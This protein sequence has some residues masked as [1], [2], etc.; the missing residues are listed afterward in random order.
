MA[1]IPAGYLKAVVSLGIL[2][3]SFQHIGTGFLYSHPLLKSGDR[4][5]HHTF[6]VTN[7]HVVE[8]HVSHVRFDRVTDG[9]LDVQPI[10][11]V[12]SL[13]WTLHSDGA[14]V[15][16]IPVLSP[17]PIMDGR[18]MVKPEVFLGDVGSP[19][20]QEWQHITEGNGVYVIGFPLGLIGRARN[21]PIIRQGV[22]SRIQ[23]WLSG[24]ETTFL[25]DSPAF[26]GNSGGPVVLKPE[27]VAVKGTKPITHSLL[28]GMVSSNISSRE[29][30]ISAQTNRPRIVFEENTGLA[31]VVPIDVIKEAIDSSIKNAGMEGFRWVTNKRA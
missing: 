24:D 6:L 8:K 26:P 21:Y 25:I 11:S 18:D 9:S 14:D 13:D 12:T 3:E 22:I 17:G 16:A 2:E 10:T 5:Q 4:T 29:V 27:N 15:A 1:L 23:D 20:E 31:E 7:R 30:A 28:I 19:S